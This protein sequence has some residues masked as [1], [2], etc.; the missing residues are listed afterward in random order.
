MKTQ[1][2]THETIEKPVQRKEVKQPKKWQTKT[3]PF[4]YVQRLN[5]SEKRKIK[6]RKQ[7]KKETRC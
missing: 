2:E 3:F 1:Y 5:N 6:P 4:H 7:R